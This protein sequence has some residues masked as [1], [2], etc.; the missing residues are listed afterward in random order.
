MKLKLYKNKVWLTKKWQSDRLSV[1]E[2]A[3]MCGV[4]T[5][6]IYSQLKEFDLL[7]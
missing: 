1:K 4:T 7:K 2:I 5:R 3:T 6:T